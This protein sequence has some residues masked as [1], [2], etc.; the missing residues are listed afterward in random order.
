[1]DKPFDLVGLG[2]NSRDY[3]FHV[4]RWPAVGESLSTAAP[5]A[6]F[7]GQVATA[8]VV[9]RRF[10]LRVAYAGSIGG[11][12]AG[13]A[14]RQRLAAEGVDLAML[15]VV[16]AAASQQAWIFA[17]DQ[18]ERTIIFHRPPELAYPPDLVTPAWVASARV[19]HLDGHDGPAAARAAELARGS[20]VEVSVDLSNV[21]PPQRASTDRLLAAADWLIVSQAFPARYYGLDESSAAADPRP[22]LDRL[23]R[24]FRLRLAALT[25]GAAGVLALDADGWHYAPGYEVPVTDTTGAGD[26]FHGGFLVGHLNAWPL[27]ECLDFACALAALNCTAPGSQGHIATAAEVASFRRSQPRRLVHPALSDGAGVSD[28]IPPESR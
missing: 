20:G 16:P 25:L 12:A 24:D 10:G 28:K 8:C 9:A 27:E 15:H 3:L 18:G 22:A 19:L 1:M 14:Q 23:Y 2:L 26:V 11:D 6:T 17:D 7:G 13:D 5:I 4:A 21:Y